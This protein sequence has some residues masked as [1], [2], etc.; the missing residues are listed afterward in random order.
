M[1]YGR[2]GKWLLRFL[3]K[4]L[5]N[6]NGEIPM[7]DD[8]EEEEL[9]IGRFSDRDEIE[10]RRLVGRRRGSKNFHL[11]LTERSPGATHHKRRFQ[12][13]LLSNEALAWRARRIDNGW[14]YSDGPQAIVKAAGRPKHRQG[15]RNLI[16]YIGRLRKA[17]RDA[18][19]QSCISMYDELGNV[20]EGDSVLKAL[21]EW[22]LVRDEANLSRRARI[23]IGS[24]HRSEVSKLGLRERLRNI[25]AWHFVWSITSGEENMDEDTKKFRKAVMATVDGLFTVNG[26]RVLWG[27]HTD[28][29]GRPHAHV[30]V[31]ARSRFG[32]RIRC[33]RHGDY[34]FSMRVELAKNLVAAGLEFD[35]SRREDDYRTRLEI[36]RGREPLR[37]RRHMLECRQ[38]PRGLPFQVPAWFRDYGEAYIERR[39]KARKTRKKNPWSWW[40]RLLPGRSPEAEKQVP[41]ELHSVFREVEEAFHDPVRALASWLCLAIDG[42]YWSADGKPVYPNRGLANWYLRKRPLAFGDTAPAARNLDGNDFLKRLLRDSLLPYPEYAPVPIERILQP[43]PDLEELPDQVRRNRSLVARS[44]N[45]VADLSELRLQTAERSRRI[46]KTVEYERRLPIFPP[47]PERGHVIPWPGDKRRDVPAAPAPAPAQAPAEKRYGGDKQSNRPDLLPTRK[48]PD[49]KHTRGEGAER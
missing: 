22:E 37:P 23:L 4:W 21:D 29:P 35:A 15:V 46:R 33:D 26:F 42:A 36:M 14:R 49:R 43:A 2:A 20:Y 45:R 28:C 30:A 13:P 38:G 31:K 8:D 19:R 17:D 7:I 18:G 5:P 47:Q 12:A 34:L 40:G 3:A 25:Q 39:G 1:S 27:I 44:L 11:H 41:P 9:K 48:F 6:T 16:R 32:R 10:A 24:G